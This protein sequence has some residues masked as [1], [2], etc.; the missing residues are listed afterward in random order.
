MITAFEDVIALFMLAALSSMLLGAF[1]GNLRQD[2][3]FKKI[4]KP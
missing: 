2:I 4:L 3:K 1:I